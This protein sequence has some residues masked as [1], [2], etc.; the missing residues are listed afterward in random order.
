MVTISCSFPLHALSELLQQITDKEFSTSDLLHGFWQISLDDTSK[1][2]TASPVPYRSLGVYKDAL[3]T[4]A[5]HY[6]FKAQYN[7]FEESE[8]TEP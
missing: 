8:R 5:F 4:N 7:D 3:W 1:L 2:M 6:L